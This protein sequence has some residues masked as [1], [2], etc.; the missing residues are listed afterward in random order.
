[1]FDIQE[2]VYDNLQDEVDYMPAFSLHIDQR[3]IAY[4]EEEGSEFVVSRVRVVC[5][6]IL[7]VCTS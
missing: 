6:N 1:M 2:S 7:V 3:E 4:T 5:W